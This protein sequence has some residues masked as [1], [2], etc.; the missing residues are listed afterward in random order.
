MIHRLADLPTTDPWAAV[1]TAYSGYGVIGVTC[2]VLGVVVWR[3][4][5]KDQEDADA[6]L[7]REI[8]RTKQERERADR[9][10]EKAERALQ[11]NADLNRDVRDKLIPALIENTRATTDLVTLRN[12]DRG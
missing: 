2:L 4:W 9:A 6:S 8:E 10:E 5:K 7:A 1:V 3:L 12:R 11:A